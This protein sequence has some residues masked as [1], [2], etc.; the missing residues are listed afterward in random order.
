MVLE[1]AGEGE[2]EAS[3]REVLKDFLAWQCRVRQEA[4]RGGGGRPSEGMFAHVLEPEACRGE[5]IVFLLHREDGDAYV[6][7]FRFIV[8][9]CFDPRERRESGLGVLSSTYYQN[10]PMFRDVVTMVFPPEINCCGGVM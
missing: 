2:R 8:Q 3:L 4:M 7:Q 9:S 1:A 10:S 6:S 5:K